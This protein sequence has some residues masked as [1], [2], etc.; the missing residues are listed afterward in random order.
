MIKKEI[1]KCLTWPF[2]IIG[3]TLKLI[4]SILFWP[5]MFL[6]NL[7]NSTSDK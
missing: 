5:L 3:Y 7:I 4:F 6:L 2:K 1:E